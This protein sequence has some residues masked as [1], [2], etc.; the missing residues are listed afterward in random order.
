MSSFSDRLVYKIDMHL[1]VDWNRP[2]IGSKQYAVNAAHLDRSLEAERAWT[3][4]IHIDIRLEI[5]RWLTKVLINLVDR[6]VLDALVVQLP[7]PI[8]SANHG[9]EGSAH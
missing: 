9:G 8:E 5:L 1:W 2:E 6:W 4:G 3:H 7:V